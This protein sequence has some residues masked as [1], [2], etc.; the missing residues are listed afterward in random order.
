MDW[1]ALAAIAGAVA[2][3]V[4]AW[5]LWRI[6]IDALDTRAAEIDS[7]SLTTKVLERPTEASS[8]AGRGVWVYQYEVHNPGRLPI[9]NVRTTIV[10]PCDVQRLHY[11][12]TLDEPTRSLHLRT[13]VIGPR[14]GDMHIRKLI[15][16]EDNR[17]FLER[18]SA[19]VVF[20]TPV[21]TRQTGRPRR[22]RDHLRSG[23]AWVGRA[24][25]TPLRTTS[26]TAS[27][28]RQIPRCTER[29]GGVPVPASLARSFRLLGP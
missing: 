29:T 10:F 3:I 8:R 11:D 20:Q 25:N 9:T 26:V 21:S 12:A 5:Q 1:N 6:R 14:G 28:V 19:V 24:G 15:I 23:D 4:A 17:A 13:P 16:S 7:V 2:A 18:T 27:A 22:R